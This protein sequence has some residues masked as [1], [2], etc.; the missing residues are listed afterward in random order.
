MAKGPASWIEDLGRIGLMW[1]GGDR[2]RRD[3]GRA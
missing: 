2:D 3:L 1:G